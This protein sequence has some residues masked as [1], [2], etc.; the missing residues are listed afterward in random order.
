MRTHAILTRRPYPNTAPSV[1]RIDITEPFDW[2][3][4]GAQ[5]FAKTP[6]Q[7]LL[8]GTLFSLA[9]LLTLWLTWTIPWLTVAFLT[10][11]I[12]VG[13]F[14]AAGLYVAARQLETDG[15]ASIRRS[16]DLLWARRT[17]LSLFVLFLVMI[18]AAWVRLSAL[19]FAL[20]FDSLTTNIQSYGDL[21]SGQFDPT[22]AAFFF[23][24]GLL[25]VVTVFITSAM[26]VPM[27]LDRDVGPITA[28]QTSVRVVAANWPTMLVWG[29]LIASLTGI[30]ILTMFVG[31][32]F[33]FPLLGYA[34]WHSY[35]QI[36]A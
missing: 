18:A 12:L 8:Y 27:I 32:I 10:G 25:L 36:L 23:G 22:L 14:L 16:F 13:P 4:A 3:G 2:L 21:L 20:T 30:G 29:A 34:T 9:C 35:R 5:T 7:S 11:L 26:S 33:V 31:M 15:A 28:I 17:N 24:V 6:A 19:I 1:R